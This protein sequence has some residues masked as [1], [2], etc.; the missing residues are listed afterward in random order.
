MFD[1]LDL[2]LLAIV[3]GSMAVQLHFE[4]ASIGSLLLSAAL[5]TSGIGGILFGFIADKIGRKKTLALAILTYGIPTLLIGLVHSWIELLVLRL[6]AGFGV[7]GAWAAGMTLIAELIDPK[8][9]GTAIGIVQ[10]GFPLGFML[11]VLLAYFVAFDPTDKVAPFARWRLAFLLAAIPA[12]IM[13]IIVLW[14]VPES[15][16][17]KFHLIN[18]KARMPDLLRNKLYLKR[19]GIAIVMDTIAMMGY[20][21]YWSWLPHYLNTT[22]KS[23]I[24]S[25]TQNFEWLLLT[26]VGA[27]LGYI[28]Y[29]KIQDHLGRRRTWTIF[30]VSE[31]IL[32]LI[33]ILFIRELLANPVLTIKFI[34]P[35][36][37]IGFLLGFFT[38]YW[39]SFGTI[40]SELFPTKIRGTFS[41][42]AFN[43][44][45]TINFISPLLV[46]FLSGIYGWGIAISFSAI[47]TFATSLI[48]WLLPETKGKILE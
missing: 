29:G 37:I 36:Y 24:L 47:A 40:L 10:S 31:G 46:G 20:W 33:S 26:Q 14:K 19:L 30:T 13:A 48:V 18:N 39:A 11:A 15:Y 32:V 28:S 17:W 44:G 43:V 1:A 35:F 16:L 5:L 12:I 7:G 2:T 27:F 8:E 4:L 25:A 45:R 9:R 3:I 41:G 21:M 34:L 6:I 42:L 22:Y 38:G 23:N